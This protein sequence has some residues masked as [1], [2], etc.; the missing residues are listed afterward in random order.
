L[1]QLLKAKNVAQFN[2][3][4]QEKIMA[5]YL[6]LSMSGNNWKEFFDYIINNQPNKSEIL[7][8]KIFL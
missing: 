1:I 5:T 8:V 2:S 4:A 7:K 3:D 6:K